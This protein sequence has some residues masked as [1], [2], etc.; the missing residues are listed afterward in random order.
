[1][2]EKDTRRTTG[3]RINPEII[4]KARVAAVT[5]KKTLG[6]WLEEAIQQ[7]LE[8]ERKGKRGPRAPLQAKQRRT[9]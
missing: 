1:M 2:K 3:I 8:T 4:H 9:A 6:Q 7:K 5:S